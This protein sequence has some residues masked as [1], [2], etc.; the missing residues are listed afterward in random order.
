MFNAPEKSPWGEVQHCDTLCP[1][2]FM[3]STENHNGTM[4]AKDVAAFLSPAVRK[5]GF[6]QS[7]Y[8]CFE[9]EFM[10]SVVLW[11]L[12]GKKLWAIPERIKDK[13]AFEEG[14]NKSVREHNPE[15]WRSRQAGLEKVQSRNDAVPV[16]HAQR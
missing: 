7:G 3:V 8:I 6:K 14:I 5:C 16:C 10:E 13:A 4:V 2:V 9:E 15:Y 1:G 11:E 12:L